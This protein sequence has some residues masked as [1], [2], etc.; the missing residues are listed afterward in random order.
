MFV[1]SRLLCVLLANVSLELY[2][3]S[4]CQSARTIDNTNNIIMSLLFVIFTSKYMFASFPVCIF[5]LISFSLNISFSYEI[6]VCV[7]L[8]NG[9]TNDIGYS[10]SVVL[11]FFAFPSLSVLSTRQFGNKTG[12]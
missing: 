9:N 4:K 10:E 1:L 5:F 7:Y 6:V 2:C 11:S 8:L 12:S 3:V